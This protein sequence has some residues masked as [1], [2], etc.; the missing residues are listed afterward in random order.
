MKFDWE[1]DEI[2][3]E[4]EENWGDDESFDTEEDE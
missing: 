2:I 4:E 3:E 1:E